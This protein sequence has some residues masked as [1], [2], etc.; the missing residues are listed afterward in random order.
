[1]NSDFMKLTGVCYILLSVL[2]FTPYMNATGKW[3]LYISTA[4]LFLVLF[5][6]A[7]F[8]IEGSNGNNITTRRGALRT[9]RFVFFA[10]AVIAIIILPNL[11]ITL[12]TKTVN[13]LSD[14]V[15]LAGLGFALGLIGFRADRLHK[16]RVQSTSTI[17][18]TG[19]N[20]QP[21]DFK[22]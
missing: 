11:V 14:A 15:T 2:R 17:D 21:E 4:A 22:L 20:T 6:C 16:F 12:S 19:T 9:L 10:C 18:S 1:M 3:L 13:M 8:A 7:Q 5:D